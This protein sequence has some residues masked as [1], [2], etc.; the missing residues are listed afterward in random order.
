[1]Y[2]MYVLFNIAKICSR[3]EY[4]FCHKCPQPLATL[5]Q[6]KYAHKFLLMCRC[7]GRAS[8][9]VLEI[10]VGSADRISCNQSRRFSPP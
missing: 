9:E 3:V 6:M 1:M 4:S 5:L 8:I 2:I 7:L 10:L